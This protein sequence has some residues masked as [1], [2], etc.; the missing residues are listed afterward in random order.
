[1]CFLPN[2]LI[3]SYYTTHSKQIVSKDSTISRQILLHHK[4]LHLVTNIWYFSLQ[5]LI[6]GSSQTVIYVLMLWSDHIGSL[7]Y[8]STICCRLLYL[9]SADSVHVPARVS[10]QCQESGWMI[11]IRQNNDPVH[12]WWI[13][14]CSLL[15]NT[16]QI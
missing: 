13:K 6:T 12:T 1:M 10:E 5:L 7:C 4:I 8:L 9:S 14:K 15:M 2:N 3:Y 16:H 11:I